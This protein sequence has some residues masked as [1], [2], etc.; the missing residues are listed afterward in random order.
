VV[1]FYTQGQGPKK[2]CQVGISEFTSF[3]TLELEIFQ[4]NI[5]FGLCSITQVPPK[6]I[7]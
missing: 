5:K 4:K 2:S 7:I 6:Q 3:S 1:K